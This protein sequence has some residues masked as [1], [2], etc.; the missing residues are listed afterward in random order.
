MQCNEPTG[1]CPRPRPSRA[2]DWSPFCTPHPARHTSIGHLFPS[3]LPF[4]PEFSIA[5]VKFTVLGSLN[6]QPQVKGTA[7]VR[8]D[9]AWVCAPLKWMDMGQVCSLR[10]SSDMCGG[11]RRGRELS[12]SPQLNKHCVSSLFGALRIASP[13]S[14]LR[15][16]NAYAVSTSCYHH[17]MW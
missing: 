17:V 12:T 8:C 2:P 3:C 15:G 13:L 16:R 11:V 7:G 14:F 9:G 6:M 1:L 5:C 4:G 10:C